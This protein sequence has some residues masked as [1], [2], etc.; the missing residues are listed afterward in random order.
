MACERAL[1]CLC[2]LQRVVMLRLLHLWLLLWLLH[3]LRSWRRQRRCQRQMRRR[4][5][6]PAADHLCLHRE[7]QPRRP[8]GRRGNSRT[9][10]PRCGGTRQLASPVMY[11]STQV[12]QRSMPCSGRA[13]QAR[14]LAPSRST[15][16][17]AAALLA[18]LAAAHIRGARKTAAVPSG[19]CSHSQSTCAGKAAAA[20][21]SEHGLW[22]RRRRQRTPPRARPRAAT[23]RAPATAPRRRACRMPAAAAATRG[24]APAGSG[25]APRARRAGGRKKG[26]RPARRMRGRA[27]C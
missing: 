15:P 2:Q 21:A 7:E 4:R 19:A 3:F 23:P 5:R 6:Q 12:H 13:R 8:A 1:K 25:R 24:G 11:S 9:M 18:R 22:C 10:D 17:R 27:W 20:A 14:Q 16:R 26:A